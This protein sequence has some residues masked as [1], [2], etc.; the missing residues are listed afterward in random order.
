MRV[1]VER[2][3]VGAGSFRA[4][5]PAGLAPFAGTTPGARCRLQ[6]EWPPKPAGHRRASLRLG[7][8]SFST[9]LHSKRHQREKEARGEAA[10]LQASA[11]EKVGQVETSRCVLF[12]L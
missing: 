11:G 6:G 1:A 2:P 5:G 3:A 8:S 12:S 7:K 9:S 10:P 4:I